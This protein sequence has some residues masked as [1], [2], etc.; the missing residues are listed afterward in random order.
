M[1]RKCGSPRRAGS[2]PPTLSSLLGCWASFFAL[3]EIFSR[4]LSA[5]CFATRDPASYIILCRWSHRA[6]A[7]SDGQHRSHPLSIS[8]PALQGWLS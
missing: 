7:G 3:M 8:R 5:L 2:L 4:L 1:Q 6:L